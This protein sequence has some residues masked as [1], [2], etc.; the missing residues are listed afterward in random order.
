MVR[1]KREK[2]Q[3]EFTKRQ[4]ARWQREKRRQRII[5]G[6]GIFIA[7]AVFGVLGAGWYITWYHPLHQTVITVNDTKFDMNYY[8]RMLK[9]YG[10]GL[11]I[12]YMDSLADEVVT[13]I[14]QNELIRQGVTKLPTPITVSDD[15]VDEKLNSYDPPL[16]KDYGEVVRAELLI[17]K[18]RNEYF[19]QKVPQSAEQR[20]ILAMFLESESQAQEVRATLEASEDFDKDFAELAGEL[21]LDSF[22]KDKKGDLGW[23]P[24]GVLAELLGSSVPGEYTFESE[25]GVLSQPIHDEERAKRV[26]YWLIKVLEREEESDIAHV[27]AMLLG[28]E[29]E[30]QSIRDKL[31]ASEDFDKDFAELAKELSQDYA[32]KESGG[33]L[34]RVVPGIVSS[35][36]D[37]F[38]FDPEVELEALSQPIRDEAVW[39]SGGYWLIKVVGKE[40][41]RQIEDEDRDLLRDKLFNEWVSTL[42]DEAEINDS[43]LNR[44]RKSW[45]IKQIIGG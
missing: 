3:R 23:R 18:L 41:A 33:D 24:K 34:G 11:P 14:E 4:L 39:T 28:S 43:Y 16:S 5:L 37:D 19:E 32:S 6:L 27:Q 44:E 42:R 21:S 17:S 30:A 10:E 1:K 45:A 2:P 38:A 25:V 26:G 29:E 20:H 35:A 40:D 9:Y 8:I 13:Y 31:E 36:F 15:E 7:V 22:S 12:Q